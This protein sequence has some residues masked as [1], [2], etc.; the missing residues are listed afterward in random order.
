MKNL[1]KLALIAASAITLSACGSLSTLGNH[2]IGAPYSDERTAEHTSRTAAPEPAQVVEKVCPAPV[3]CQT[4]T[5]TAP[6]NARIR[7]LES[8]LA[9]CREGA[10]RVQRTYRETLEK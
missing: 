9:Q 1:G 5:D 10:T 6:L 2:D 8:L 4:C 3:T 7:E